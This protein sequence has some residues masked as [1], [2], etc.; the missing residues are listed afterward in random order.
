MREAQRRITSSLVGVT[1][2]GFAV[3]VAL[4]VGFFVGIFYGFTFTI[5]QYLQLVWG[6]SP[7]FASV[8]VLPLA[9]TMMPVSR[10]AVRLTARDPSPSGVSV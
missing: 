8:Q 3:A 6:A 7:L 5:V 1:L 4:L 10:L 9:A 2:V